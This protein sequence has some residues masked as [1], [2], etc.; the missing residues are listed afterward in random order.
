MI[1]KDLSHKKHNLRAYPSVQLL[2]MSGFVRSCK[3]TRK[4]AKPFA[5]SHNF[6]KPLINVCVCSQ[7]GK[8]RNNRD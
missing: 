4:I 2:L 1:Y 3:S 7:S 8:T 6:E 5:D